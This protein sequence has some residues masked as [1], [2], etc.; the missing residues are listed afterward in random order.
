LEFHRIANRAFL[1]QLRGR[2]AF[3]SFR[4]FVNALDRAD[5]RLRAAWK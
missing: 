1:C 2:M 4:E 3:D 5:L